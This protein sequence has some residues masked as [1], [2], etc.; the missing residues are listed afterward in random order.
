MSERYEIVIV[1][2]TT[3]ELRRGVI[4]HPDISAF[5]KVLV[6]Y[7]W[8]LIEHSLIATGVGSEFRR[9]ALGKSTKDELAGFEFG[10]GGTI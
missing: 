8:L 5:I 3:N 9:V 6:M 1:N 4:K 10:K 7:D 2:N